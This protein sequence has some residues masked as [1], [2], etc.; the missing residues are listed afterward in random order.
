M[1][2]RSDADRVPGSGTGF[3]AGGK[4]S[5]RD[6]LRAG[7]I[8]LGAAALARSSAARRAA[9][10]GKGKMRVYVGTYTG[11]KSKGIYRLDLDLA[12]G[13]LTPPALAAEIASPSFVAIHPNHRL[14]YAVNEVA[15]F[16]DGKS[17]AVSAF[18]IDEKTGDL[19]L[20]NQQSSGGG[21][22]CFVTVD[23]TGKNA[24]VANYGGG[25]VAALPIH[26]DG[27]L[28]E[29]TAFIQH[30]GTSANPERQGGPHAHSINVDAANRFAFAADL[31]LDKILVYRF[32][33]EK[34]TLTPNDPPFAAVAPA[35]GPRHFAFHP[36]GR[37]AYVINEI[38]C[39]VTAFTYDPAR[40][41]LKD[42]QTLSTLPGA[43]EPSYS[44]AEVQ[45]HPSGKFL[46]GSNRGHDTIAIFTIEKESGRLT[47]IGHQPTG[48]KTPR[49]FGIDPTG[50][51]LIA[52]NQDSD[53]L[54][55]FRIDPQSGKLEPTG[56]TAEVPMPVCVKM[57][58]AGP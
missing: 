47:A 12:S 44:T 17:G 46:Y 24:L 26:P 49:N 1:G 42:F 9:K 20:L 38:K 22:P 21:G 16:G 55:V 48:G 27:S 29:A 25:S 41:E 23:K 18:A 50:A 8:G 19:K 37:H 4:V 35:S 34:G 53:S 13:A 14:L 54:V 51:F 40:G 32:D 43:L 28:G 3:R 2:K 11:T 39:T 5:R 36:D 30:T 52:A 58:P 33:P 45:V 10:A 31:G 6:V 57:I 7:A 56:Y 15:N